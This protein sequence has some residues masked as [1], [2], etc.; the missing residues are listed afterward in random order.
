MRRCWK[1]RTLVTPNIAWD[2]LPTEL[3][4]DGKTKGSVLYGREN[5]VLLKDTQNLND[6]KYLDRLVYE[7]LYILI[8]WYLVINSGL[9]KPNVLVVSDCWFEQ[10]WRL[11]WY[12]ERYC[13][14]FREVLLPCWTH[15]ANDIMHVL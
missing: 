2:A 8:K 11:C 10:V 13:H 3:I 15:G 6:G 4:M 9:E 14:V 1:P 5:I 7:R 12:K